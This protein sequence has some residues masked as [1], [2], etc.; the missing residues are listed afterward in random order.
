VIGLVELAR[1]GL[2]LHQ[3]RGGAAPVKAA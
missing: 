1:S 3:L 2:T